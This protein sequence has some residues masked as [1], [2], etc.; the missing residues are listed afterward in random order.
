MKKL[1]GIL[2]L[3]LSKSYPIDY[4]GTCTRLASKETK[5]QF[6]LVKILM[7]A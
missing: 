7:L 3:D 6:S 5:P 2:V 4:G 1:L